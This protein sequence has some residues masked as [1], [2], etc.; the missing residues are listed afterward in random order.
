MNFTR[1]FVCQYCYQLPENDTCCSI[2]DTCNVRG[3]PAS[4]YIASCTAKDEVLC[5]RKYS[6]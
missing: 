4:L 6:E 2:N 1:S 5:L 3:T